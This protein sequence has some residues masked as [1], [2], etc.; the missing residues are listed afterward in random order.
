VR[1]TI[2]DHIRALFIHIWWLTIEGQQHKALANMKIQT[3]LFLLM[4][5]TTHQVLISY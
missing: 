1:E 2:K 5:W 4:S 3:N